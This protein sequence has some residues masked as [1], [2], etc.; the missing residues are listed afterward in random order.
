MSAQRICPCCGASLEDDAKF[1]TSC[2]THVLPARTCPAC[3]TVLEA[4]ALFC[5]NCGAQLV[6]PGGFAAQVSQAAAQASQAAP[7]RQQSSQVQQPSQAAPQWQQPSQVQQAAP[8]WQQPSQA[9]SPWSQPAQAQP[10]SQWP[11]SSQAQQ[12]AQPFGG[13]QG[14]TDPYSW[15]VPAAAAAPAAEAARDKPSKG[16]WIGAIVAVVVALLAVFVFVFKP[17]FL[18]G[19]GESSDSGSKPAATVAENESDEAGSSSSQ[20]AKPES[21]PLTATNESAGKTS[22]QGSTSKPSIDEQAIYGELSEMYAQLG[23]FDARIADVATDF[24][25][26]NSDK[27]SISTRQGYLDDARRLLDE[28]SAFN[29]RVLSLEVPTASVNHG[30][31]EK[32]VTCAY[33]CQR[34]ISVIVEAWGRSVQYTNPND[35]S[36]YIIEPLA[37]D[38]ENNHNKYKTEF[39]RVYPTAAPVVP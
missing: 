25:S 23:A 37:R 8:Q 17:A 13:Q 6:V 21:G 14:G 1:C 35:H 5:T 29:T 28:V 19:G 39:D 9:A 18:F 33:D 34:R 7:Q 32:I 16:L 4:D 27:F 31:Y 20:P 15:Q 22:Q 3:G 12:P 26:Y 38:V 2:G 10:A 36:E 30:S 11:Q 24:N